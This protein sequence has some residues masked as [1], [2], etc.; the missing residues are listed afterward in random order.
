[1]G[2]PGLRRLFLSPFQGYISSR[3][4]LERFRGPLYRLRVLL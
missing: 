2:R 3:Y 4:I 1:M